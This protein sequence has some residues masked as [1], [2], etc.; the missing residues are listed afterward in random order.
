MKNKD[1][2]ESDRR[3]HERYPATAI[4]V[5]YSSGENF[6]FSYLSN[7]SEMGIFIRTDDPLPVG[8]ELKLRFGD[9][10]MNGSGPLQLTGVVTW[11]NPVR[12]PGG[13]PNAGMGVKFL[14]LSPEQRE[15]VVELV[16]TVAY[17]SPDTHSVN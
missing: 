14:E 6:L 13:S 16:R 1:P 11:V 10:S 5:D 15:A 4:A 3:L 2:R 8:T 7:I 9:V 17:L 12:T